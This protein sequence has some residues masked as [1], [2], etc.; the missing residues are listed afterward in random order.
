M[1]RFLIF[2]MICLFA[3]CMDTQSSQKGNNGRHDRGSSSHGGSHGGSQG[4]SQGRDNNR[5]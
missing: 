1:K 4:D 5:R 3:G 2:G